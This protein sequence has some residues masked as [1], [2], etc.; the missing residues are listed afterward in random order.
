MIKR[1]THLLNEFSRKKA[2]AK[3][4]QQLQKSRKTVAVNANGTSGYTLQKGENA[5]KVLNHLKKNPK[6]I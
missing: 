2:E 1:H 3:L 6:A 4:V 5:G